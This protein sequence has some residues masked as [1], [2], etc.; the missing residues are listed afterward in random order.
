M[1]MTCK[2]F[3]DSATTVGHSLR[4]ACDGCYEEYRKRPAASQSAAASAAQLS[5]QLTE[6]AAAAAQL[7]Q[8]LDE[9]STASQTATAAH[10]HQ[11]NKHL[12]EMQKKLHFAIPSETRWTLLTT[13][14]ELLSARQEMMMTNL[15]IIKD[16]I[17]AT[18]ANLNDG[19]E[20]DESDNELWGPVTPEDGEAC[21]LGTP[22]CHCREDS[23]HN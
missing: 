10:L 1:R 15:N 7:A 20:S 23:D 8:Q 2:I 4:A 14:V 3:F 13:S 5:R 11:I 22:M 21:Y 9:Q 6:Q 19:D 17:I 12:H 16:H 18:P